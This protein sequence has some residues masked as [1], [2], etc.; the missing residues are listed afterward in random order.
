MNS[1]MDLERFTI[2]KEENTVDIGRTI[3]C[4]VM[5]H[6]ITLMVELHIKDN[7]RM[8]HYMAKECST[9]KN[10]SNYMNPMIFDPLTNVRMMNVGSIMMGGL[11][12]T[13]NVDLEN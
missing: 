3:K 9:I 12:M 4:K 13:K 8:I 7:G 5:V 1:E 2:D 6:F 11:S 10:Q